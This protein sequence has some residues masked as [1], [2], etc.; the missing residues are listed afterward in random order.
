M[1]K[2]IKRGTIYETVV[3]AYAT[4]LT[5][6][7]FGNPFKAVLLTAAITITKYPL[8]WGFHWIYS[9]REKE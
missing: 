9:R 7:L 3:F 6:A 8:Y 2:I 4:L 5:W 1:N